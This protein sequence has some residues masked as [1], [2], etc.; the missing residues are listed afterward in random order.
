MDKYTAT[1]Q[2][3]KNGYAAG[4]RETAEKIR[5][6]VKQKSFSTW[7]NVDDNPRKENLILL[8]DLNKIIKSL[9]FEIKG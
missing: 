9:G 6:M 8:S 5:E 4:S 1:E 2:A 7:F 3:Y